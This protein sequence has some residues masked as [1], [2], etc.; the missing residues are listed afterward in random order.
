MARGNQSLSHVVIFLVVRATEISRSQS[1][2]GVWNYCNSSRP[3]LTR[4]HQNLFINCL[5]G[6][7]GTV[8]VWLIGRRD[9]LWSLPVFAG[10]GSPEG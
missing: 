5:S 4:P 10:D 3:L 9:D 6:L 2:R 8:G 1:S 7:L